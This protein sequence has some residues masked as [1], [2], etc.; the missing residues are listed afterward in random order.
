M[1]V[2]FRWLTSRALNFHTHPKGQRSKVSYHI[3]LLQYGDF[4]VP[5]SISHTHTRSR[6]HTH[7][8]KPLCFSAGALM[9]P[10]KLTNPADCVCVCVCACV[11]ACVRVCVRVSV[12]V[13]V[14]V[15]VCVCVLASV[16]AC[17]SACVWVCVCACV[18][19]CLWVCVYVALSAFHTGDRKCFPRIPCPA[20][21]S[22]SNQLKFDGGWC[23]EDCVWF[24]KA[25]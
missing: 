11:C 15:C 12:S 2:L 14:C 13:C 25:Y 16:R 1:E 23:L 17:E 9:T 6:S 22:S 8:S 18:R 24:L 7:P 10:D 4:F 21:K 20:E 5:P 3:S 19:V